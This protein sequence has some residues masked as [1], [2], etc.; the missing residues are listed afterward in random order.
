[1]VGLTLATGN[2]S[3]V[4]GPPHGLVPPGQRLHLGLGVPSDPVEEMV[5]VRRAEGGGVSSILP[6]KVREM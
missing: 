2:A 6:C 4:T 3:P 5:E 1:M